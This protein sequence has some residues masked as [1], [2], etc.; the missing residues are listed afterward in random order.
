M[1]RLNIVFPTWEAESL[2]NSIR[3]LILNRKWLESQ[4]LPCR[5]RLRITI[6]FPSY[7]L[8]F[9]QRILD[10]FVTR[11]VVGRSTSCALKPEDQ[12]A[13]EVLQLNASEGRMA[14]PMQS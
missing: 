13:L 14:L 1:N 11:I 12:T 10:N 9:T 5:M 7:F 6:A 8:D 2:L 3:S 4:H